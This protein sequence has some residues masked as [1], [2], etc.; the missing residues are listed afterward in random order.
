VCRF[1]QI[2]PRDVRWIFVTT[3][4]MK[5][6]ERQ[7]VATAE[8][9]GFAPASDSSLT[10]H[11]TMVDADLTITVR[12]PAAVDADNQ[13]IRVVVGL[14]SGSAPTLPPFQVNVELKV[15]PGT[16]LPPDDDLPGSPWLFMLGAKGQEHTH[17]SRLGSTATE[18]AWV[19]VFNVVDPSRLSPQDIAVVRL[20]ENVNVH[21]VRAWAVDPA[22]RDPD[23]AEDTWP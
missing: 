9:A 4:G 18:E 12:G 20:P 16:P 15:G 17:L 22:I 14:A 23:G 8:A 1:E 21:S 2:A 13:E 3:E 5:R 7:T 10:V 11:G 19:A 6:G